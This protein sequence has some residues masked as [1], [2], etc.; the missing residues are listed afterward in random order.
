M[1]CNYA[2]KWIVDLASETLAT[3]ELTKKVL[4]AAREALTGTCTVFFSSVYFVYRKIM[5]M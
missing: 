4:F 1:K 3:F 5:V 2:V